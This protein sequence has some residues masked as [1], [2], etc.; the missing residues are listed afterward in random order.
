LTH[1]TTL[2]FWRCYE[3]LTPIVRALADKQF[4]LLKSDPSHPSLH[5]KR[6]RRHRSARIGRHHRA[7]AVE[8]DDGLLWWWIGTHAEYDR[9]TG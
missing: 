5:F 1:H 8:V 6:V 2:G 7:L 4:A 9:L 3:A